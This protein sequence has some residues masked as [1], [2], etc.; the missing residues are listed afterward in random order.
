MIAVGLDRDGLESWQVRTSG[1]GAIGTHEV[2][3]GNGTDVKKSRS[4]R[5]LAMGPMMSIEGLLQLSQEY[6]HS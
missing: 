2:V 3:N 1:P 5:V 4:V 6:N